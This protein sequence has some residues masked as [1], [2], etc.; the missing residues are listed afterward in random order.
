MEF[1]TPMCLFK[2]F[3]PTTYYEGR[4]MSASNE[5][6]GHIIYKELKVVKF[7]GYLVLWVPFYLLPGYTFRDLFY[8]N[9]GNVLWTPPLSRWNNDIEVI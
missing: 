5:K 4:L 6:T 2:S 1:L 9:E 7:Y 8:V 3:S